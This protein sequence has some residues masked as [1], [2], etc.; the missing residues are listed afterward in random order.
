MEKLK[1]IRKQDYSKLK[2]MYSSLKESLVLI[3]ENVNKSNPDDCSYVFD[4]FCPITIR[5]IEN[6]ISKGWNPIREELKKL[7]GG[8]EIPKSE[9]EIKEVKVGRQNFILL[10]FIGGITYAEIA[11]IRY[12]NKSKKNFKFFILTTH[13][14]SGRKILDSLRYSNDSTV[15]MQDIFPTGKK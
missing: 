7:P 1:L 13:I 8:V 4:G 3:N 15:T 11:A 14:T 6:V 10:V 12:L 5:L 9:K 2:S